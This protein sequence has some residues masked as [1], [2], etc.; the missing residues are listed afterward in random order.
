MNPA[1]EAQI[2]DPADRSRNVRGWL[3][4]K[5]ERQSCFLILIGLLTFALVLA[6]TI[7]MISYLYL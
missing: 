3:G 5:L 7:A 1:G 6:A 2:P 4:W